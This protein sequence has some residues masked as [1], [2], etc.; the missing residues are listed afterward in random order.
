MSVDIQKIVFYDELGD[1]E[2][3]KII[4]PKT[5]TYRGRLQQYKRWLEKQLKKVNEAIRYYNPKK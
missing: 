1:L 3:K 5:M 2:S 4:L